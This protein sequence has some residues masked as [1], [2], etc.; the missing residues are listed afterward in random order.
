MDRRFSQ[1][2]PSAWN[3]HRRSLHPAQWASIEQEREQHYYPAG[4]TLWSL[5]F[6]TVQMRA[7][8]WS[9]DYAKYAVEYVDAAHSI[10]RGV[11]YRTNTTTSGIVDV[12]QVNLTT[13]KSIRLAKIEL[14]GYTFDGIPAITGDF[15]AVAFQ[16]IHI[17]VTYYFALAN[18]R[19]ENLSIMLQAGLHRLMA[20]NE[21]LHVHEIESIS[22]W[23][24]L[25]QF[26]PVH[27]TP[28]PAA[29]HLEQ[30]RNYSPALD[31]RL[32]KLAV[33]GSPLHAGTYGVSVYIAAPTS[34]GQ[35]RFMPR[36]RSEWGSVSRYRLMLPSSPTAPLGGR[37][38]RGT[39]SS[40][41]SCSRSPMRAMR[42]AAPQIWITFVENGAAGGVCRRASFAQDRSLSA[43]SRAVT[44]LTRDSIVISY[45]M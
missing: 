40:C 39:H 28:A 1:G 8:S 36:M 12:L 2:P 19:T 11:F 43:Y 29:A 5:D 7:L 34:D 25:A 33:H 45:Y 17:V 37:P 30:F 22:T 20:L 31:S 42:S 15:F 35:R 32:I 13:G 18:W 38:Y 23:R 14:P 44:C 21:Y 16:D 4:N 3:Q 9:A 41:A 6:W 10:I 27:Y 24:P 26:S